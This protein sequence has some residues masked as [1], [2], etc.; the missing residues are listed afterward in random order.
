MNSVRVL[1]NPY[2]KVKSLQ[3]HGGFNI[4]PVKKHIESAEN[5]TF[6]IPCPFPKIIM[7][8]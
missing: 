7:R 5:V 8:W 3:I 1:V 4:N 6:A 2:T